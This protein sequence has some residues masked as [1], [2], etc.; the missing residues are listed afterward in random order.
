MKLRFCDFFFL[1]LTQTQ[2][3]FQIIF[4]FPTEKGFSYERKLRTDEN[5]KDK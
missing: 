4:R 1:Y 3:I 2:C 5:N